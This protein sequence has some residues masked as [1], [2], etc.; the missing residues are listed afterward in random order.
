[1]QWLKEKGRAW[2]SPPF[3]WV[4]LSQKH[5]AAKKTARA[6]RR[7]A[8]RHGV[9]S[10]TYEC[11]PVSDSKNLYE[12]CS[13][14]VLLRGALSRI[15]PAKQ[16]ERVLT[17][18]EGKVTAALLLANVA[19]NRAI[20][21]S[22]R[23]MPATADLRPPTHVPQQPPADSMLLKAA[24]SSSHKGTLWHRR[25]QWA[26]S[27]ALRGRRERDWYEPGL[28]LLSALWRELQQYVA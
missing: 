6:V 17:H 12:T 18:T 8:T 1:M 27:S 4:P 28:C 2:R 26:P 13:C 21:S 14:E 24:E 20:Y 19:N 22:T 10:I 23:G 5:P 9:S 3:P 7:A 25:A 11:Q 16:R 15:Q